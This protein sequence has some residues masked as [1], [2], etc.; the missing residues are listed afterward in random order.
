MVVGVLLQVSVTR[1]FE[2]AWEYT[3]AGTEIG[4]VAVSPKGDLITVGAGRVLFFSQNGTLLAEEPFG[5]DVRMSADGKY[6]ASVYASTLY[7]FLNPQ[8]SGSP[9]QQRPVKLWDYELSDQI[10]S[11]EMN[12]DGSLIAGQTIKKNLFI[13]DTRARVGRGNTKVTDSVVKISG[14]GSSA[15]HGKIHV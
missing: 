9:E 4:G 6:T 1:A 3:R 8:Q 10:S 11:F 12:R 2:P 5:S 14:S 7:Y 15:F 13:M